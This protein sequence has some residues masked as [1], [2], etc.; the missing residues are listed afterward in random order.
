MLS[1]DRFWSSEADPALSTDPVV[2]K[3]WREW[4]SE[5]EAKV[6]EGSYTELYQFLFY[7]DLESF[8]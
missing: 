3:W 8:Q 1:A 4:M 6:N 2:V 5:S 7:C